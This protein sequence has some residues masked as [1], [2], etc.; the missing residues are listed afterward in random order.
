MGNYS[1]MLEIDVLRFKYLELSMG[2]FVQ[3]S[4]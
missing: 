4:R 2:F 3:I 1:P